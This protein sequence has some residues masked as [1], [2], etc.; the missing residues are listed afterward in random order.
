MREEQNALRDAVMENVGEVIA[1]TN[2]ILKA[3]PTVTEDDFVIDIK[4][5]TEGA[6][7]ELINTIL[8]SSQVRALVYDGQRVH[9]VDSDREET[10]AVYGYEIDLTWGNIKHRVESWIS[11]PDF[12][13]VKN[14]CRSSVTVMRAD[15]ESFEKF[16]DAFFFIVKDKEGKD[17]IIL[18]TRCTLNELYDDMSI[19]HRLLGELS[20]LMAINAG[21]L[22]PKQIETIVS[23]QRGNESP[24]N[25]SHYK[26]GLCYPMH[27]VFG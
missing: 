26:D 8:N 15:R 17:V 16:K 24:M 23:V 14:R 21:W 12:L 18:R 27:A 7:L 11:T 6:R 20:A 4:G 1:T 25:L 19:N 10:I 5:S 22:D 2:K 9:L 13:T 3:A